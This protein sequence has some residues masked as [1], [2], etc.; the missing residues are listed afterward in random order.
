MKN[1]SVLD[2]IE[3]WYILSQTN[4]QYQS[5]QVTDQDVKFE[6]LEFFLIMIPA[7]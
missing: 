1:I 2:C 5:L 7:S 6:S 3:T 4:I